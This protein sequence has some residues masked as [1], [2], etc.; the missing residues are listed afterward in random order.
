MSERQMRAILREVCGELDRRARISPDE[1]GSGPGGFVRRARKLLFPALLGAGL[2]LGGCSDDSG[3]P[4]PVYGVPL[5]AR[6]EAKAAPAYGVPFPDA[7]VDARR[8]LVSPVQPEY[9]AP[10]PDAK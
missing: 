5:D 10:G 1:E 4:A 3:K 6:V 2:A 9:M 8:D 7:K